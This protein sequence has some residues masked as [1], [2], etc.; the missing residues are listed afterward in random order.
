M[1][2]ENTGQINRRKKENVT[3]DFMKRKEVIRL[4]KVKY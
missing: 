1:P 4:R 2:G 3:L